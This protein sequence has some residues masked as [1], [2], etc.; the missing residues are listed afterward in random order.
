VPSSLAL[1][2]SPRTRPSRPRRCRSLERSLAVVPRT[3]KTGIAPTR[4]CASPASPLRRP[5]RGLAAC[6]PG[7]SLRLDP[8]TARRREATR[9]REPRADPVTLSRSGRRYRSPIRIGSRA[10]SADLRPRDGDRSYASRSPRQLTR[11]QAPFAAAPRGT[12][13]ACEPSAPVPVAASRAPRPR[14][15]RDRRSCGGERE[16][17]RHVGGWPRAP[18]VSRRPVA[19]RCE[20]QC[21]AWPAGCEAA[22]RR[23]G[24]RHLGVRPS[25]G[26]PFRAVHRSPHHRGS[27]IRSPSGGR[28]PRELVRQTLA[29]PNARRC[30]RSTGGPRSSPEWS[31]RPGAAARALIRS[32]RRVDAF[33]SRGGGSVVSCWPAASA[34]SCLVEKRA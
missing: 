14:P 20:S 1:E 27:R 32:A 9:L 5:P 15:S 25:A 16:A 33:A 10:A 6:V 23:F 12:A 3:T 31:T 17:R 26:P 18:V 30:L 2:R 22:A 24:P 11:R 34:S 19:P 29:L 7:R 21:R 28:Q 8:R 13:R 4:P